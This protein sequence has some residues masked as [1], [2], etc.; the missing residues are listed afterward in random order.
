[1]AKDSKSSSTIW[2][3][4]VFAGA[5]LGSP[6]V[7]AQTAPNAPPKPGQAATV[8]PPVKPPP[9]KPDPA[10]EK[11]DKIKALDTERNAL[12]AKLVETD[13]KEIDALRKAIVAKDAAIKKLVDE[14]V[15]MRKPRPRTPVVQKPVGRGFVLA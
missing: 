7:S 11:Q 3:T 9:G 4:V 14:I 13:P 6:L 15:A 10:V 1:M 12:L 8:A 2:R 5:M